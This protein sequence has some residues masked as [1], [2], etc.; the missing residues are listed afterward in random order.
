MREAI[1]AADPLKRSL[2]LPAHPKG[3]TVVV[4]AGKVSAM[5]AKQLKITGVEKFRDLL[6]L[7]TVLMFPADI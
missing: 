1:S 3:R 4:G 6:S 5:M 7:G 2:L